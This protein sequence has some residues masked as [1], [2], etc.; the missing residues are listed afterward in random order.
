MYHIC[1]AQHIDIYT[2]AAGERDIEWQISKAA[3]DK[4]TVLL[5]KNI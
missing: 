5:V 3:H 4:C 2:A 1:T